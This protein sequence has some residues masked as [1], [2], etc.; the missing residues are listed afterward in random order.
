MPAALVLAGCSASHHRKRADKEVYGVLQQKEGQLFG[1]TNAFSID[2]RYSSRKPDDIKPPEIIEERAGEGVMTITLDDALKMAYDNNRQYQLRKETLYLTALT[3]T[4]ARYVFSPQ[5]S[6]G[7]TVSGTRETD[8]DKRGQVNSAVGVDQFLKTGGR[9]GVTLANDLLRYFTGSPRRE[10]VSLI[11]MN[12]VQP[13]LRG[14]W[15]DVAAESLTQAERDVIYEIRSFTQFQRSFAV[16][17]VSTYFRLLRDKDT[18]RNQYSNYRSTVLSSERSQALAKDRLPAVQ[19]DQARQSELRAKRNYL[20][21]VKR[22]Q[23]NLDNFK[24]T[25][26]LPISTRV[27]LDDTVLADLKE[28][29]LLPVELTDE[30][31]YRITLEH[32]LDLLNEIDRFEDQKRKIKVASNQLKTQLNFFA[33]GSLESN[34]P[35][36]YTTFD[37]GNIS[38]DVGLELDLPV[39]RLVQ[40][41]RYRDALIRFERQI[42]TF[43]LALDDA[44]ENVSEGLRTLKL[45]R[46][47]YEIERNAL[48]L[49]NRRV[50]SAELLVKA[51]RTPIRDLLEAQDAQIA[52]QNAVTQALVDYHVARLNLLRDLGTLRVDVD[53][54]WLAEQPLPQPRSGTPQPAA[55]PTLLEEV[56][57]PDKLFEVR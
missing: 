54:F 8:G 16:D 14:A 41:N 53:K 30:T 7:T 17:I 28:I 45:S 31:G 42:R 47:S 13:L 24:I 55:E 49:A 38:A 22:Y 10:A 56:I 39:N 4:E 52:S 6:A 3:L 29:G 35:T 50:E 36:D 23:D 11:S 34:G 21:A 15:A 20:T 19:A 44:R 5:F 51:G 26:G 25:L 33:N 48:E 37:P 18:V 9:L 12:L 32:Q 57:P 2:T 46:Q 40:R 27:F 1:K 43:S